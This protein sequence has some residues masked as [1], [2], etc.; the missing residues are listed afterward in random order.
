MKEVIMQGET[1]NIPEKG[2]NRAGRPATNWL[3][4]TA[5]NAWEKHEIYK[6]NIGRINRKGTIKRNDEK[7]SKGTKS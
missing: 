7:H 1:W 5:N 3:I 2:D 4:E 6:H